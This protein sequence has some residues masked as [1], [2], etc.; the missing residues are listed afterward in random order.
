MDMSLIDCLL[1]TLINAAVCIC[2]P[3]ALMLLQSNIADRRWQF[4]DTTLGVTPQLTPAQNGKIEA[5]SV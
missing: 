5:E 1:I 4:P 3:K 2:L